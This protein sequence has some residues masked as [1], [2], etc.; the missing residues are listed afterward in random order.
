MPPVEQIES[1]AAT[2]SN[3]TFS[4]LLVI[5]IGHNS[6]NMMISRNLKPFPVLMVIFSF[7]I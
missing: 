2:L 3:E 1:F 5:F 7:V 6:L 4:G